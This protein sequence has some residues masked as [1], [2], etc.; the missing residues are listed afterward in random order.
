MSL[1]IAVSFFFK[2]DTAYFFEVLEVKYMNDLINNQFLESKKILDN[3]FI[4][5]ISIFRVDSN[6]EDYV[7]SFIN[8]KT[9]PYINTDYGKII[10]YYVDELNDAEKIEVIGHLEDL[11]Y[12][13]N[14]EKKKKFMQLSN[15]ELKELTEAEDIELKDR[16]GLY[17][18]Y[19]GGEYGEMFLSQML[20]SLGYEKI[21]SK[22]AL[23]WGQLSPTG[24]DIPYIDTK[25]H[26]LILC[27]SKLWK[28]FNSAFKSIKKDI[29]DIND[30]DKFDK[31]IREWKKKINSMPE[32][33]KTWFLEHKNN[34]N[35]KNFFENKFEIIVLGVVICNEIKY[36]NI[37]NQIK[38]IFGE[39][40]KRRYKVILTAIPIE[41]KNKLIAMCE[42]C[43]KNI[44]CEVNNSDR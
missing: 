35:D 21:L 32:N 38:K 20:F 29:D 1:G 4:K 25:N 12:N 8:I 30:G 2:M 42:K 22:L 18:S 19:K 36:E 24:I 9:F 13:L 6:L 33:V 10:E 26:I 15:K 40:S 16:T 14:E 39:D 28:N 3:F 41:D 44:L 11:L 7:K 17:N 37:E 31:E 34:I 27:E 23:Q 43:I 5:T